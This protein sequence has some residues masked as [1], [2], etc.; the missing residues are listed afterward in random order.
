MPDGVDVVPDVRS[1]G[2]SFGKLGLRGL[3]IRVATTYDRAAG[4]GHSIVF[5]GPLVRSGYRA[6]EQRHAAETGRGA[7]AC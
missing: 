2:G 6:V 5:S 1:V 3:L 7:V 4:T